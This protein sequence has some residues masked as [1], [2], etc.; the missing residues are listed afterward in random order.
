MAVGVK[1]GCATTGEGLVRCHVKGV[2][3][4]MGLLVAL[5][6]D[7]ACEDR[8]DWFCETVS[9]DVMPVMLSTQHAADFRASV[10]DLDL[11]VVRLSALAC[12]PVLSRRTLAHVRRGDP[13]HLQLALVT[14]GAFRISQRGN[15]SVVAGGLVLTDTSRP[16]EGECTGGR[17]ETV[18]MQIPRPD[19]ALRPDRV[20]RLLAQGMA[21]DVGSGAI[22]AGF[23]KT[24][25]THG[26]RCGPEELRGMGSVAL[27]LATAFLAQQLG[28]PDEAPAE[29]RAQET[30][31]RIYRFIENNLGDPGL[32]P[33]VIADRH[34]MSLRGLYALFGDQQLTIAAR[35]RQSR[36]E[37]AHADLARGEL[38]GQ[39]VQAIAARWGFSTATAFS[40]AFREA[41]GIT[42]TEH[43]ALSLVPTARRAQKPCTSR[44][45]P[46]AARA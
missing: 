45:P 16:S 2:G 6:A 11:G 17:V 12:S 32:T 30:L 46:R 18:V 27:D 31:Q 26:P 8:F 28:D 23:L 42:P 1:H 9:S 44:T 22:L 19:L 40:R 24:L 34:N 33:Q 15:E 21:A 7:V 36:L 41:Y 25:L 14:Q 20:D 29:A 38:G 37:R 35:I 4:R 39:P 5:D 10:T 3:D 43:R 13:E